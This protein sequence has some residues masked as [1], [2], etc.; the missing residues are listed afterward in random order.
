MI[1]PA[2]SD[3]TLITSPRH[4]TDTAT[5]GLAN[6][7]ATDSEVGRGE[8]NNATSWDDFPNGRFGDFKSPAFGNQGPWGGPGISVCYCLIYPPH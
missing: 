8:L 6:I 1:H 3:S 2:P 4:A 5:S 7:P